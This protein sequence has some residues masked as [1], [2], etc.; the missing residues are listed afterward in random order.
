MYIMQLWV[1]VFISHSSAIIQ[2]Q[3]QFFR[4]P[5]V[6]TY[7]NFSC[8][9]LQKQKECISMCG[10]FRN[11]NICTSWILKLKWISNYKEIH[12]TNK[13][14]MQLNHNTTKCVHIFFKIHCS[15]YTGKN[16]YQ[17]KYTG[18]NTYQYVYARF[19][20]TI[21]SAVYS[22]INTGMLWEWCKSGIA[23]MHPWHA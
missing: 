4:R 21:L 16:T 8:K 22:C 9:S 18:K 5:H 3:L 13:I 11:N 15:Y 10:S 1:N 7:C 19:S 20:M 14:Y 17:Y 12:V 6:H 2:L 23:C